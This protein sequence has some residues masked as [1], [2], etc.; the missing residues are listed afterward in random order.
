MAAET[1]NSNENPLSKREQEVLETLAKGLSNQEIAEEL[2][3]SVNTVRVHLR[4]IFAKLEAQSRTEATMIAMQ[5]GWLEPP[6]MDKEPSPEVS[7]AEEDNS[8]RITAPLTPVT[9][10]QKAYLGLALLIALAVLIVPIVKPG[11]VRSG[12]NPLTDQ[13]VVNGI[14]VQSQSE[15]NNRWSYRADMPTGRSRLAMAAYGDKI[16]LIGGDRSSGTTGLVEIFD[17]LTM[18]W[19]EAAGKPTQTANIQ[20]L[21]LD[22]EIFVPG[23]CTDTG[24]VTDVLEIF[25][26]V[27]DSWRTGTALPQ[28]MCA[29]AAAVYK[30]SVYVIG[31]WNGTDYLDTVYKYIPAEDAWEELSRPFPLSVGFAGAAVVEGQLY[32]AGGYNGEQEYRHVYGYDPATETWQSGPDLNNARGGLSLLAVGNTLYALGGGWTTGLTS[33]EKWTIGETAWQLISTPYVD[34][35]R[36]FGATV[37]GPEI[38][39][40]GGWNEEHLDALMTYKTVFKV[41]IPVS[42]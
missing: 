29:Y 37:I 21:V 31:G 6:T 17:P 4:N 26:P 13:P 42:F 11:V 36:N 35:W 33:N 2:V 39:I 5:A 18:A 38:Y 34:Q 24:E 7:E 9:R 40:A 20:A 3:I 41:F 12:G 23:G 27:E 30:E 19:Q 16:Y 22:D 10:E 25:N 1:T 8:I 14:P 28:P 32:V 15:G